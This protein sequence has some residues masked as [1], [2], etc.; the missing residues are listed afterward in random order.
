MRL[1]LAYSSSF[2]VFNPNKFAK[3]FLLSPISL[4]ILLVLTDSNSYLFNFSIFALSYFIV[5]FS[6]VRVDYN[7]ALLASFVPVVYWILA[8]LRDGVLR[9]KSLL[10][11]AD[12]FPTELSMTA[13]FFTN[14]L[15]N[16]SAFLLLVYSSF[17]SLESLRVLL[18]CT[19][20][21]WLGLAIILLEECDLT[22]KLSD[23]RFC[24]IVGRR[25]LGRASICVAR[26]SRLSRILVCNN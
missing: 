17:R 19:S 21:S 9:E 20:L 26:S 12:G 16:K 7:L 6:A 10:R 2:V 24:T 25:L 3:I 14:K 1:Y 22:L 18:W 15:Y 5:C 23:A 13:C 4:S 8:W 11:M